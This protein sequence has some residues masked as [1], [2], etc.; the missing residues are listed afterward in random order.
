MAMMRH[1]FSCLAIAV[2][3]FTAACP[4]MAQDAVAPEVPGTQSREPGSVDP[5]APLA[6]DTELARLATLLGSLHYLRNLCGETGNVWRE[7]MEGLIRDGA[8]EA[9]RRTRLIAAFNDGYRAFSASYTICNGRAIQTIDA[10]QREG[11]ALAT[12][13]AT[14]YR[15]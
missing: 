7:Q 11:A 12:E 1:G 14:R 4:A 3:V 10:Y 2:A 5:D 8:I 6:Y 15:S 13:I 9:A